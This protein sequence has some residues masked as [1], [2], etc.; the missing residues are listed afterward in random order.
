MQIIEEIRDRDWQKA[1]LV[2]LSMLLIAVLVFAVA[3]T[4]ELKSA[5]ARVDAMVQKAF[6]E[7]CEL[8]EGMAVNFRKL[9]VAGE[10]GQMQALLNETALQTQGAMS[11]LALLPLHQ[12]TVSATLKF[13]NQAGDFARALSVKL[14]NGGEISAEDHRNLETLS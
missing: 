4:R 10:K 5:N 11:D 14:G 3:Q 13:I 1:G 12:D 7:T 2:A 8:T 6:Y 9:L